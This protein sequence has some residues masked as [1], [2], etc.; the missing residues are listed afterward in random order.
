MNEEILNS[1]DGKV[2]TEQGVN[3]EPCQNADSEAYHI[4]GCKP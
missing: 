1:F 2:K 3:S 4:A